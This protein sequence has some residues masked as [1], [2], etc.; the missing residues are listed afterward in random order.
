[1]HVFAV[2]RPSLDE[3]K[4]VLA[5]IVVVGVVVLVVGAD[6]VDIVVVGTA[7]IVIGI[8][9]AVVV[10]RALIRCIEEPACIAATAR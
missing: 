7:V 3:G 8:V 1:M 2:N 10:C 5:S 6:E 4:V 9:V